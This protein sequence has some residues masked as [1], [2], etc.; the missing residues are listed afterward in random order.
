VDTR[1]WLFQPI[2]FFVSIGSFLI[3]WIFTCNLLASMAT[4]GFATIIAVGLATV[5]EPAKIVFH[6]VGVVNRDLFALIVGIILTLM[7]IVGTLGWLQVQHA[8]KIAIATQQSAGFRSLQS[9]IEG[10]ETQ[11][12]NL[13]HTA[14][15][16]PANFHTRKQQLMEEANALLAQKNQLTQQL[17]S[18]TPSTGQASSA[19]Y[20]VLG[21]FFGGLDPELVEL[22]INATYGIL[23]ELVAVISGV[24]VFRSNGARFRPAHAKRNARKGDPNYDQF[25]PPAAHQLNGNGSGRLYEHAPED[26]LEYNQED[27][28]HE[29]EPR[30][31]RAFRFDTDRETPKKNRLYFEEPTPETFTDD[32]ED[33][34]PILPRYVEGLFSKMGKGG[35]LQGRRSVADKVGI[36]KGQADRCHNYLKHLNLIDVR[37][38]A[39]YANVPKSQMLDLIQAEAERS[40]V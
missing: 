16:M 11:I 33:L 21:K 23:L 15:N 30:M 19:L 36:S 20:V 24:Y 4:T 40:P 35:R 5:L 13:Q 26:Y 29:P 12:A 2:L 38:N 39:T 31:E 10:L 14:N 34:I 22:W 32:V 7:S 8:E 27:D 25:E 1:H 37:G 9:Q 17:A 6:A 28:L 3:S 18:Y